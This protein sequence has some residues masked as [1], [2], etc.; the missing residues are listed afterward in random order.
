MAELL[1]A[2]TAAPNLSPIARLDAPLPNA[3]PSLSRLP[4]PPRRAFT[5]SPSSL[6]ADEC[7]TAPSAPTPSRSA[8][9]L[10]PE[11][12]ATKRKQ[13]KVQ[14]EKDKFRVNKKLAEDEVQALKLG[15]KGR[16][17]A[18]GKKG[19]GANPAS[20]PRTSTSSTISSCTGSQ[21]LPSLSLP[22]PTMASSTPTPPPPSPPLLKWFSTRA[23]LLRQLAQEVEDDQ[24]TVYALVREE[25]GESD[26]S[27]LSKVANICYQQLSR[28]PFNTE[29]E[30]A[31]YLRDTEEGRGVASALRS[32][33]SD[34]SFFD[35]YAFPHVLNPSSPL[36]PTSIDQLQTPP[37][38]TFGRLFP[39]EEE[40]KQVYQDRLK[41][42]FALDEQVSRWYTGTLRSL[43][44]AERN[45]E[46]G[47]GDGHHRFSNYLTAN[48]ID[49]MTSFNTF[50]FWLTDQIWEVGGSGR[51]HE[52]M[53]HQPAREFES[54]FIPCISVGCLNSPQGGLT[55]TRTP[56]PRLINMRTSIETFL[57]P[58]KLDENLASLITAS[59][60]I[61]MRTLA[62]Q[63]VALLHGG[64]VAK[65]IHYDNLQ[66][67]WARSDVESGVGE[68]KG[69]NDAVLVEAKK[70]AGAFCYARD[71]HHH[72]A[73][74][75]KDVTEAEADT[76]ATGSTYFGPLAGHG[77]V[78]QRQLL[79]FTHNLPAKY[80]NASRQDADTVGEIALLHGLFVDIRIILVHVE[81]VIA[82][83]LWIRW[84]TSIS[85]SP[86]LIVTS[87]K[88]AN[89]LLQNLTASSLDPTA[90][91]LDLQSFFGNL[92]STS[93]ERIR[94]NS[95]PS[96][97]R[98]PLPDCVG[99]CSTTVVVAFPT[100]TPDQPTWRLALLQLD[101]GILK[102]D[103]IH[104]L[105]LCE[106]LALIELKGRLM[107][108]LAAHLC[109][110]TKEE[111][112]T[113]FRRVVEEV[114]ETCG[115]SGR[116]KEHQATLQQQ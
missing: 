84:I 76:A 32:L 115:L 46:D 89:L 66:A 1:P 35:P 107:E 70:I 19:F 30:F 105:P 90:T 34:P 38:L 100:A 47:E 106:L 50:E 33:A 110:A 26:V 41:T 67:V 73:R 113:A 61:K 44:G 39:A 22:I 54:L 102:Y 85:T 95:N 79:T 45:A 53:A 55:P 27:F 69:I 57:L 29:S 25:E 116:I 48:N 10:S 65:L 20:P 87:S 82:I 13:V 78:A 83:L 72:G 31:I 18:D 111:S 64:L 58:S 114:S 16:K 91:P 112:L 99:V 5:F 63:V 86:T 81:V 92:D 37:L 71:G 104:E 96:W 23:K 59:D 3:H 2:P 11:P 62:S 77:P 43:T 36:P 8:S 21:A 6:A 75:L 101:V 15:G 49:A 74:L 88:L 103:P 4:P 97:H 24:S 40:F 56:S 42:C 7:F 93:L 94:S 17:K 80:L 51:S 52:F 12:K 98:L 68:G 109:P 108:E 28:P 60:D 9:H 14:V